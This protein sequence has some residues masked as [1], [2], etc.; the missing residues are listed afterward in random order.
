MCVYDAIGIVLDIAMFP[1]VSFN[2][3]IIFEAYAGLIICITILSICVG[4]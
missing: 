2:R 3:F 4:H 1:L